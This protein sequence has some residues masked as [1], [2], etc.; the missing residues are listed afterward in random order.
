MVCV[1]IEADLVVSVAEN[2]Y[3]EAN[4]VGVWNKRLKSQPTGTSS[5]TCLYPFALDVCVHKC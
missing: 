4:I 5:V 2:E 1:A 3:I